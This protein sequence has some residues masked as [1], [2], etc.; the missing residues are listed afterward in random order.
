NLFQLAT[1][2]AVYV[3]RSLDAYQRLLGNYKAAKD[4]KVITEDNLRRMEQRRDELVKDTN[5]W[6]DKYI[7]TLRELAG[8][9]GE[10]IEKAMQKYHQ[11]VSKSQDPALLQA[12]DV[13]V[14]KHLDQ[15][16]KAQ[17][18]YKEQWKAD[19]SKLNI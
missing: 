5:E 19:L 11:E 6:L 16:T 2:R 8:Y 3:S 18:D 14:R 12:F 1:I 15:Y 4:S 7:S 13:A 17:G 10:S 9:D